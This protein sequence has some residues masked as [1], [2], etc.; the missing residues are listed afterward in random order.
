MHTARDSAL[1]SLFS[2]PN[3]TKPLKTQHIHPSLLLSTYAHNIYYVKYGIWAHSCP[4]GLDEQVKLERN[5][6]RGASFQEN[7]RTLRAGGNPLP[8]SCRSALRVSRC[9]V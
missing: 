6:D 4:Q 2:V 9:I 1:K 5:S 7:V 8:Q 3:L